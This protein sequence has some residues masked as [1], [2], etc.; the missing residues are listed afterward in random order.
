ALDSLLLGQAADC[1]PREEA[2]GKACL[3]ELARNLG[4]MREIGGLWADPVV[5]ALNIFAIKLAS[6]GGV[7]KGLSAKP[8]KRQI[9]S[10]LLDA[11]TPEELASAL[12]R[13]AVRQTDAA[14]KTLSAFIAARARQQLPI[15]VELLKY[16]VKEAGAYADG[17]AMA[18]G[19]F[20]LAWERPAWSYGGDSPWPAGEGLRQR[21][22]IGQTPRRKAA[23]GRP[24]GELVQTEIEEAPAARE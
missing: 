16:G 10:P 17:S 8:A 7:L 4:G 21:A 11:L 14:R 6:A 2:I 22:A 15:S 23:I 9:A 24:A 5:S 20:L 13:K 3:V 1:F 12:G 19:A 18:Q